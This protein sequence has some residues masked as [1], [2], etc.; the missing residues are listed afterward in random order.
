MKKLFI[1]AA[2]LFSS[3]TT[4]A[5]AQKTKLVNGKAISIR[6]TNEVS[7]KIKQNGSQDIYAIVDRDVVDNT[8]ET[9]LIRRG[10]PVQLASSIV[11]AKG[12]G[13]PGSIKI[14][15]ISTTSVDGQYISLQGGLNIQGE[16]RKGAALGCG[17]G[18]GL[19]VLFP[20]GFAFL[21]IQGENVT[22]P[23]NTLIQNVVVNDTY[24]IQAE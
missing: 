18:L 19:T 12:V 3:I 6:I 9:V 2:I 16:D 1:I 5:Y 7:S 21:A 22:I 15:C 17:L 11:K 4:A 8:G 23:T 24:M 13:K 14:D 10:T 20:V